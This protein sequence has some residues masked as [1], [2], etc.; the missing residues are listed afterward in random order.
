MRT[1]W[2]INFGFFGYDITLKFGVVQKSDYTN[3]DATTKSLFSRFHL[4]KLKYR[5][6]VDILSPFSFFP[7]ISTTFKILYISELE[8]IFIYS[9]ASLAVF[10]SLERQNVCFWDKRGAR[11]HLAENCISYVC[12]CVC[13]I[14]LADKQVYTRT[15]PHPIL[16]LTR[17]L[18]RKV[19]SILLA[20]R[21]IACEISSARDHSL[22]SDAFIVNSGEKRRAKKIPWKIN[23]SSTF[24]A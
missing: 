5:D 7:W 18:A 16:R 13:V 8:V 20:A 10:W 11:V 14:S 2:A 17:S 3:L 4:V 24:R 19:S 15:P 23:V 1:F 21:N 22:A 12:G 9:C 6:K